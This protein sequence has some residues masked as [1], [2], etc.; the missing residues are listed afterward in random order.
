MNWSIRY[1]NERY[2]TRHNEEE[3]NYDE[4][5]DP[6]LDAQGQPYN[7]NSPYDPSLERRLRP[8]HPFD[9]EQEWQADQNEKESQHYEALAAEEERQSKHDKNH[10]IYVDMFARKGLRDTPEAAAFYRDHV[11]P[12][13]KK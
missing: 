8:W 10:R 1:A 13:K 6:I 2:A 9:N 3:I 11:V 7:S 5:G 12:F 4:Y